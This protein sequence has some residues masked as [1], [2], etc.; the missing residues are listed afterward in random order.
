MWVS[1]FEC[2]STE[3]KYTLEIKKLDQLDTLNNSAG[4]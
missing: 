4:F 2:I 1:T 3:L